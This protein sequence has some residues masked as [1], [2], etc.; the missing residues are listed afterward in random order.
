L[1]LQNGPIHWN[2]RSRP[3]ITKKNDSSFTRI[4]SKVYHT[5]F[6]HVWFWIITIPCEHDNNNNNNNNEDD[7][8]SVLRFQWWM[9][10]RS[11]VLHYFWWLREEF[12]SR[13]WN[14]VAENCER[15]HHRNLHHR[16][17]CHDSNPVAELLRDPTG[18]SI[19]ELSTVGTTVRYT[20][21]RVNSTLKW[22]SG[23]FFGPSVYRMMIS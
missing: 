7:E 15:R 3:R 4:V 21:V 10:T 17:L 12:F 19:I 20:H 14:S 13:V 22:Y 5:F 16:N 6:L 18:R 9:M 2:A 23:P 8:D 1:V 11:K